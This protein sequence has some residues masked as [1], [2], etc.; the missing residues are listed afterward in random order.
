[1]RITTFAQ[2]LR[3]VRRYSVAPRPSRYPTHGQTWFV[4]LPSCIVRTANGRRL[5]TEFSVPCTLDVSDVLPEA[6]LLAAGAETRRGQDA[7][8]RLLVRAFERKIGLPGHRGWFQCVELEEIYD[9]TC[10]QVVRLKRR[11]VDNT[12]QGAAS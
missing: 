10:R 1:M 7:L 8:A 5:T 6:R 3:L 9:P 2:A 12:P 11:T 4:R